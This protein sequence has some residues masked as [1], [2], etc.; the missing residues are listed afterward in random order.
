MMMWPALVLIY[1]T[2]VSGAAEDG[3]ILFFGE[4]GLYEVAMDGTGL[5]H[6]SQFNRGT[7]MVQDRYPPAVG[8]VCVDT[9]N[10]YVVWTENTDINLNLVHQVNIVDYTQSAPNPPSQLYTGLTGEV[11]GCAIDHATQTLYFAEYN[12][13]GTVSG[14]R[15]YSG[16]IS[17]NPFSATS[18]KKNSAPSAA[19]YEAIGGGL[20]YSGGIYLSAVDALGN[21]AVSTPTGVTFFDLATAK[22]YTSWQPI[23]GYMVLQPDGSAIVC[24]DTDPPSFVNLVKVDLSDANGAT[25]LWKGSPVSGH[26]AYGYYEGSLS[27]TISATDTVDYIVYLGGNPS[28]TIYKV[29]LAGSKTPEMVYSASMNQMGSVGIG[30]LVW[31]PKDS[32]TDAPTPV[33][34]DSPNTSVPTA[35]PTEVPTPLP[36][37]QTVAPTSVPTDTPPVATGVPVISNGTDAPDVNTS[38]PP[39]VDCSLTTDFSLCHS[40]A[41]DCEWSTVDNACIEFGSACSLQSDKD[42][43]FQYSACVWASSLGQCL[44]T[45]ICD[46]IRYP[47]ECGDHPECSWSKDTVSCIFQK[48][49]EE[50]KKDSRD[51]LAL[52]VIIGAGALC[53]LVLCIGLCVYLVKRQEKK[54][55][56]RKRK[57]EEEYLLKI[58][59]EEEALR[60][61]EIDENGKRLS[62]QPKSSADPAKVALLAKLQKEVTKGNRA[63]ANGQATVTKKELFGESPSVSDDDE[64]EDGPYDAP[65]QLKS[66]PSI[67]SPNTGI[68]S[69]FSLGETKFSPDQ[70]ENNANLVLGD[71]QPTERMEQLRSQIAAMKEATEV[72]NSDIEKTRQEMLSTKNR[73]RVS[74]PKGG[75]SPISPTAGGTIGASTTAAS[76]KRGSTASIGDDGGMIS[77]IATSPEPSTKRHSASELASIKKSTAIVSD[78]Q[79]TVEPDIVEVNDSKETVTAPSFPTHRSTGYLKSIDDAGLG[80]GDLEERQ[81]RLESILT[82]A[83]EP[84]Q[85]SVRTSKKGAAVTLKKE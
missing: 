10:K 45:V 43:C 64:D 71:V 22:S 34:T 46:T 50:S 9:T 16:V 6:I 5:R 55:E 49:P 21:P 39:T 2:L 30:P 85:R 36:P 3:K 29:D 24:D 47:D 37:G 60:N 79:D 83:P 19:V 17:V 31:I 13:G 53:G 18:L 67:T 28:D 33:P 72:Q 54:D 23:M 75:I 69:S 27:P 51:N 40:L 35:V 66:N 48:A 14:I 58:E 82:R 20:V 57:E 52:F 81:R 44:V 65:L 76:S 42:S 80:E 11:L 15:V 4:D 56:E 32:N 59:Q 7:D 68:T 63:A 62:K 12:Y 73:K 78:W 61:P 77:L 70:Q 8:G 26:I 38:A 74:L 84:P 1:A 41:P 25:S